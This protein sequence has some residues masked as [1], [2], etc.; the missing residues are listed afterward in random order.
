[1]TISEIMKKMVLLSNGNLQDINHFFKVYGYAKMI[2]ECENLSV[3]EQ[4]ILEI[5]AILH[6]IACP[7]CREK[8]GNTD[9]KKQ[10]EEGI[11][12]VYDFLEGTETE[13]EIVDRVAYLVG[14][15]HTLTDIEGMDYQILI[16]ADYLVNADENGYPAENIRN[17]ME[18]V[19]RTDTG[20]TLLAAIYL[21]CSGEKR[22]GSSSVD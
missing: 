2:G 4:K 20:R 21:P 16:E 8:Y 1:M 11:P 13:P 19:F 14:H 5:A 9:G 18:S 10:E 6:D 17:M 7:L 3:K 22:L 15:H 12:L